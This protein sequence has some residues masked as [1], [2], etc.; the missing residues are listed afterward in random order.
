[1]ATWP[2]TTAS[3]AEGSKLERK[4]KAMKTLITLVCV[5]LV[6]GSTVTVSAKTWHVPGECPTIQ[7]GIDSAATGD[8]VLVADGTYTGAGNRDIDFNGE[9]IVLTS[10]NGPGV[11][12]IDCEGDSLNPHRGFY[13]HSEEGPSSVVRRFTI[14]N[15]YATGASLQEMSGG[16]I[17]CDSLS[18]PTIEANIITRNTADAMGAGIYCYHASAT[19][20]GNTIRENRAYFMGGGICCNSCSLTIEGNTI[21]GDT[22][23]YG[24]G[25]FCVWGSSPTIEYNTITGN[26]AELQGGGIRC[27]DHS[28]PTIEGN[29]ITGNLAFA[30]GGGILCDTYSSPAIRAN[31]I[32]G[33]ASAWGGGIHCGYYSSPMIERNAITENSADSSGSGVICSDFSSPTINYNCIHGNAGCAITN[34]D[35]SMAI[36][37]EYNW[38]GHASGPGGMCGGS[39]DS[40]CGYMTCPEE[41]LTV[42]TAVELASFAC[43]GHQ[44]RVE[45]EWATA[46]EIDNAGF[47]LHRGLS[48]E[49]PFTRI[50][51]SLIPARGSAIEGATYRFNDEDVT[52]GITYYYCLEDVDV[53]GRGTMHGP[54]SAVPGPTLVDGEDKTLT[55]ASLTLTQ[56]YP[57]P[58]NMVTEI[59]Y[60]L[61]VDTKVSLVIYSVAGHK[62]KTLVD[63]W[64]MAGYHRCT[65]NAT[66]VADGL[67]LCRLEAGG[68]V[69]ARKVVVL[70]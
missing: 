59:R 10:E 13:F 50:N 66:D 9:A 16:G 5:S 32:S 49:G 40:I 41:W 12:I 4:R 34:V 70:R 26:V 30:T 28:S 25:I 36:D 17:F 15:G 39:G 18:S 65:W 23:Y 7:C 20:T 63:E 43:I 35:I 42:P 21:T 62:I 53:R 6:F 64:Q 44:G 11:T 69:A 68:N 29:W 54:V 56:S 27:H 58:F 45:V 14:R 57:N 55:P 60:A 33:N 47:N 61:P 24:G 67:Y 31:T 48:K 22:A 46:A 8:T 2:I 1:M 37:V 38:W 51:R 52:A 3:L 19:I